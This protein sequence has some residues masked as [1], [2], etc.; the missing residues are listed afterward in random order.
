[1]A[2]DSQGDVYVVDFERKDIQKFDSNG[3]HLLTFSGLGTGSRPHATAANAGGR[4][5]G[6]PMG[7]RRLGRIQQ[8]SPDGVF[9]KEIRN[10]ALNYPV[11]LVVDS[12]GRIFSTN[13]DSDSIVVLDQ[14]GNLIATI[15]STQT[16]TPLDD[17]FS[18]DLD[19]QGNV[20]IS[21]WSG[22][23]R[24][25]AGRALQAATSRQLDVH[26]NHSGDA[27]G[28]LIAALGQHG[29]APGEFTAPQNL[30]IGPDG[31]LYVA[32]TENDR[33]QIFL[34]DSAGE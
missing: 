10:P 20:Y 6:Q 29:T 9:L 34:I 30:A 11:D 4:F 7:G 22:A 25:D 12:Q 24:G 21:V 8:F 19:G 3:N 13:F 1:M 15:D 27:G 18:I 33:I 16:D 28:A 14:D 26:V 32:D 2:V 17:P 31:S 23:Q 5:R